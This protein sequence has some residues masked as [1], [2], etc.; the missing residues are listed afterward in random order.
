MLP[1]S[2]LCDAL[3]YCDKN[4]LNIAEKNNVIAYTK[5]YVLDAHDTC[6]LFTQICT[7][8][9][10]GVFRH[11]LSIHALNPLRKHDEAKADAMYR[12]VSVGFAFAKLLICYL[13]NNPNLNFAFNDLFFMACQSYN[14][15]L[16][17]YLLDNG[18]CSVD[19]VRAHY[20]Y[21]IHQA[22]GYRQCAS[23]RAHLKTTLA[24]KKMFRH[25]VSITDITEF[26]FKCMIDTE[27]SSLFRIILRKN[28]TTLMLKFLAEYAVKKNYSAIIDILF[29]HMFRN[30]P[31]KR[32]RCS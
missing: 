29:Q 10:I 12:I 31:K 6:A 16:V 9:K 28:P 18:H 25:Y 20:C 24:I 11:L 4:I 13:L 8:E 23:A 3:Q 22:I 21:A 15:Q 14:F 30:R 2:I 1:T 17:V 19:S 32:V 7:W 26:I 5:L 27:K